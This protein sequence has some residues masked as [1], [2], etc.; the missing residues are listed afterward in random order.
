M[1]DIARLTELIEPEARALGFDLVRVK[2]MASE[3]GEGGQALQIMAEDPATG[4]L[5]IDQC[6]ALSRRVSEAIDAREA[7]GEVLVEGAYHL[8]VSSP[9][10]DRPLTRA[11]DFANWAGHEAKISMDRDWD[12]QRNLR[13]TLRG[14]E[15]ETVTILDRKAGAIAVPL[16]AIHSAQLVLTDALIAATRPLDTSGVEEVIGGAEEILEAEED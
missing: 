7:A 12:G 8:E 2:M 14:I 15:G 13:G 4:Q 3:A 10:I 16:A 5:V 9:G 11:K 1:A 6:A